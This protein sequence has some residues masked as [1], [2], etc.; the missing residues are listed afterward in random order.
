MLERTDKKNTINSVPVRRKSWLLIGAGIVT[1]VVLTGAI[2]R[3][4]Q[5]Q[6]SQK[7]KTIKTLAERRN[8]NECVTQGQTITQGSS[9]YIEVQALLIQCKAGVNWQNVQVKTLSGHSVAIWSVDFSPDGQ[10]LASGS[11]DKTIKLWNLDAVKPIHT[12]SGHSKSVLSVAFDLDGQTLASSS[13][14][15]T[16]KLWDLGTGKLLHT[17]YGHLKPVRSVAFSPDRQSLASGGWDTTRSSCGIWTLGN[18]FAT[19]LGTQKGFFPLPLARMGRL[20]PVVARTTRSSCGIL[21]LEN[22][23]TLYLDIQNQSELLPLAVTS[24]PSQVVVGIRQSKFGTYA[25]ES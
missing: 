23:C 13:K 1:I 7:L 20:L 14:D 11:D 5:W 22:C 17:L 15:K 3:L 10:T 25:Q 16:I 4:L 6:D 18:W 9:S 8:Y 19:S 12:L 2:Y 24:K 21:T